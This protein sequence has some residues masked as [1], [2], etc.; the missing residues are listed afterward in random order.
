MARLSRKLR[1][2]KWVGTMGCVLI[3][4]A[5]VGSWWY[6]LIFG[7]SSE[8]YCHYFGWDNG[9]VG[10]S[11][12]SRGLPRMGWH[13]GRN[14]DPSYLADFAPRF[15]AYGGGRYSINLPLWLPFL[16]L[17]IPTLL[18]WRRDRKPRPGFCRRCDYD[19]TGN[20]S[21]R[22]PECGEPISGIAAPDGTPV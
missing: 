3:V 21:G 2:C 22:C 16:A 10:Y 11:Q 7:W 15:V 13:L 20:A 12:N 19:L 17:L 8:R 4:G 9:V 18:L 1:V 14:R 6:Y 5:F